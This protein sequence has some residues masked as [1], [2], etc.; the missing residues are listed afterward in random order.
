MGEKGEAQQVRR[1]GDCFRR[2]G[3]DD[4]SPFLCRLKCLACKWGSVLLPKFAGVSAFQLSGYVLSFVRFCKGSCRTE[5]GKVKH[6]EATSPGGSGGSSLQGRYL[7][8]LPPFKK[9][10]WFRSR[11]PLACK[12]LGSAEIR[13]VRVSA[14]FR[15]SVSLPDL[16]PEPPEI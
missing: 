11:L 2:S 10:L 15:Q 1:S 16:R 13:N 3:D 5:P 8:S 12:A 14:A 7:L 9:D 6:E 4:L